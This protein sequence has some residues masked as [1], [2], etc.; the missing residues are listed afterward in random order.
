MRSNVR[1][2]RPRTARPSPDGWVER[3][4]AASLYLLLGFVMKDSLTS[5]IGLTLFFILGIVYWVFVA[6]GT[7]KLPY[8]VRYHYLQATFLFLLLFLAAM[9]LGMLLELTTSG[10]ELIGMTACVQGIQDQGVPM[11]RLGVYGVMLIAAISQAVPA[12]LGKTPRLP[13]VTPNVTY[14]L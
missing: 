11:L 13:V 3:L 6:R 8:F 9:L 2:F 7:L 12:L 1:P 14:W 5:Q 10:C 4:G